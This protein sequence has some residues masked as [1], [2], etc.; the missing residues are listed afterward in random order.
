MCEV[1]GL[2]RW[3]KFIA[4]GDQFTCQSPKFQ[5]LA[6]MVKENYRNSW[7]LWT[8]VK[9][10]F[11][12]R[13]AEAFGLAKMLY[14]F[15]AKSTYTTWHQHLRSQVTYSNLCNSIKSQ[16]VTKKHLEGILI[17]FFRG[18]TLWPDITMKR[19]ISWL[20]ITYPKLS[21]AT[22][23]FD[24]RIKTRVL[25]VLTI[26]MQLKLSFWNGHARLRL[27]RK[28]TT[29]ATTAR[30]ATATWQPAQNL[31]VRL[32]ILVILVEV[33]PDLRN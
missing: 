3:K 21:L 10:T 8:C 17:L 28:A 33:A 18:E 30:T 24:V 13:V 9:Y 25:Q 22:T 7:Q 1:Y 32:N 26:R 4:S 29:T 16:L 11:Y 15:K 20:A 6:T 2:S 5:W 14:S 12:R 27:R 31:R 19:P 23:E